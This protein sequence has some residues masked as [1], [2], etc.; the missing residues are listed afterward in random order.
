MTK[1]IKNGEGGCPRYPWRKLWHFTQ[2]SSFSEHTDYTPTL[3]RTPWNTKVEAVLCRERYTEN[4][5]CYLQI[6]SCASPKSKNPW[7]M[8]MSIMMM[9]IFI[10][11]VIIFVNSLPILST[12][13]PMLFDEIR[14]VAMTQGEKLLQF[15]PQCFKSMVFPHT[16]AVLGQFGAL[17]I[18]SQCLDHCV[19]VE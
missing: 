16:K 14:V 9:V 3:C 19:G 4:Q 6:Q 8:A 1:E 17:V 13:N 5:K 15:V 10:T 11:N 18:I 2:W 12:L 7:L